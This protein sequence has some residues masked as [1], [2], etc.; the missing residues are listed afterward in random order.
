MIG[1]HIHWYFTYKCNL[2]CDYCFKPALSYEDE[3]RNITLANILSK[4]SVKKVTI[5]GGEPTL[6]RNL[7]DVLSI[8]K[9][10]GKYVSLHT[11]G[12]LLDEDAIAELKVDDIALP[13]DSIDRDTQ[14]ELRGEGFLP[15]FDRLP[16]LASVILK[17]HIGLG[18]HTVFTSL[19]RR[20]I[21]K[22][23]DLIR[24][25]HFDYW[26]IYEFN[27]DLA[28]K[29]VFAPFVSKE[30][31]ESRLKKID[32]LSGIGTPAKGY[33]DCLLAHFLLT[34]QKMKQRDDPRIQFV[35]RRDISEPYAFLDNS[36]NISN[37]SW[38]SGRERRVI[39]NI[40]KDGFQAV[41]KRLQ[42]VDQKGWELDE[43]TEEDFLFAII[44]ERPIWARL[45]DG[46]YSFEEV[47]EINPK[48]IDDVKAL[49]ELHRIR[50]IV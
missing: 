31:L 11:N 30:E 32:K 38:F 28:W 36:G 13:I 41:K 14:R 10:G 17:Y 43:K 47:E 9:E 22:L 26:R 40:M 49:A 33:T 29:S 7:S 3:R 37:Y 15:A 4:S 42:E 44:G 6:V 16:Q 45:W 18:Y 27:E 34:E 39:G 35:G 24:Q 25:N 2:G 23:Y 46:S 5:T 12:V 21:Q 48:F 1:E 19:N 20:H 50:T 8:L